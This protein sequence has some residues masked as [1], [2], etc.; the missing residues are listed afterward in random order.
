MRCSPA[1]QASI[2]ARGR[3]TMK[4]GAYQAF[5][6]A[7]HARTVQGC[8]CLRASTPVC[9]RRAKMSLQRKGGVP[10]EDHIHAPSPAMHLASEHLLL[11]GTDILVVARLDEGRPLHMSCSDPRL[12]FFSLR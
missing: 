3:E 9:Y 5:P 4:R 6:L 7:C 10:Y 1:V 8:S 2:A 12:L 11:I